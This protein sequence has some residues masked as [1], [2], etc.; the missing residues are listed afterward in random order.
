MKKEEVCENFPFLLI[1]IILVWIHF[2]TFE[3]DK[4][5]TAGLDWS[6]VMDLETPYFLILQVEIGL[7][8]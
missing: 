7:Q 1:P 3:F 2:S 5:S 8:G 6:Y 4:L